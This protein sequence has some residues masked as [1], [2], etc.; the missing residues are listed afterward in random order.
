MDGRPRSILSQP[1]TIFNKIR[2]W[3]WNRF[4]YTGIFEQKGVKF[5]FRRT[6]NTNNC[7]NKRQ[8]HTWWETG[9]SFMLQSAY[10]LQANRWSQRTQYLLWTSVGLCTTCRLPTW[11]MAI[12]SQNAVYRVQNDSSKHHRLLNCGPR[13]ALCWIISA[14]LFN[15]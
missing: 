15:V 8:L 11:V 12:R 3:S 9:E 6:N 14:Q 5:W 13:N 1:E 7:S 4:N 2:T 10:K